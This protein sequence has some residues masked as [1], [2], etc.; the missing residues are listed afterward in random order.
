MRASI[1][2]NHQD[3]VPH[4]C[5]CGRKRQAMPRPRLCHPVRLQPPYASRGRSAGQI[6][7][8]A[9]GRFDRC[10][11][12]ASG[13][14]VWCRWL[15]P[16]PRSSQ[17]PYSLSE[18]KTSF[19]LSPHGVG[20][21]APARQVSFGARPAQHL[22]TRAAYHRER[23]R[24]AFRASQQC[25]GGAENRLRPQSQTWITQS[26]PCTALT[27]PTPVSAQVTDGPTRPS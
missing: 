13:W 16:W 4:V 2:A 12:F 3:D 14:L 22:R 1:E 15:A 20:S 24:D 10:V 19:P 23:L 21:H 6:S 17:I 26:Q 9:T 8:P 11:F 27:H 7:C 25:D 5:V 18:K